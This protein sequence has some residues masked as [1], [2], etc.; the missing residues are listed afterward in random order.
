MDESNKHTTYRYLGTSPFNLNGSLVKS[1]M[2]WTTEV[3]SA[4][5][6][7]RHK[8]GYQNKGYKE[9]IARGEG[10][11]SPYNYSETFLEVT[12]AS[13]NIE[14]LP[15]TVYRQVWIPYYPGY[16]QYGSY[17]GWEPVTGSST[18]RTEGVG[19]FPPSQSDMLASQTFSLPG[20][21]AEVKA[22]T[23]FHEK[24][25]AVNTH[26]EGL[27]AVGQIH[28]VWAGIR[29]PATALMKG[30][31]EFKTW[32]KNFASRNPNPSSGELKAIHAAIGGTW[33]ECVFGWAPL[34]S[35]I[36]ACAEALVHI[37]TSKTGVMRVSGSGS[38][39]NSS[40][41]FSSQPGYPIG[42]VA[43]N[44]ILDYHRTVSE[45]LTVQYSGGVAM[46]SDSSYATARK[47]LGFEMENFAPTV[48]ELIP[49]SFLVDY[50][51]NIGDIVNQLSKSTS[52]LRYFS[53]SV[54]IEKSISYYGS[55]R[56]SAGYTGGGSAGSTTIRSVYFNR[57]IPAALP[58][59]E[60]HLKVPPFNSKK[61][62]NML[63]LI[64]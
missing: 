41:E 19:F 15:T 23:D 57:T 1:P 63:A 64:R 24:I 26:F 51:V 48:W 60:V 16:P 35:D 32:A 3:S 59:A 33:L 43:V 55:V 11:S 27:V 54:K 14:T 45:S 18:Y 39:E 34:L 42:G 58:I 21:K 52:S 8:A 56:P 49:Y 50:F 47:N 53:R 46:V 37:A 5:S 31:S 17:P 22:L 30:L 12:D 36:D 9:K 61:W 38:E 62:L 25:S 44:A 29:H 20:D 4:L 6:Y 40:S 28:E 2:V 13:V 7:T 10:V